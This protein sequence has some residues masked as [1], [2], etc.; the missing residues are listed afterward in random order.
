MFIFLPT[1]HF[2]LIIQL[3]MLFMSI[4]LK[5]KFS[6]CL[7]S[8]LA[9]GF[10]W[11]GNVGFNFHC[12]TSRKPLCQALMINLYTINCLGLLFVRK[13]SKTFVVHICSHLAFVKGLQDVCRFTFILIENYQNNTMTVQFYNSH[14]KYSMQLCTLR[15]SWYMKYYI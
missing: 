15:K 1:K 14:N 4:N 7:P 10:V 6:L 9:N 2:I 5:H 12:V 3:N 8:I 11:S 13:S